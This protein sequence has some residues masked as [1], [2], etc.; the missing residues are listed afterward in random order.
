MP[1]QLC[2]HAATPLEEALGDLRISGNVLLHESYV[3]P[4]AIEVP[5]QKVLQA[6]M[7]VTADTRVVPFHLVKGGEFELS[8][9][10][11]RSL[12]AAV[13]DVVLCPGGRRH[14]MRRGRP[15]RAASM[16]CILEGKSKLRS[17]TGPKSTELICGV[18][19]MQSAP[20]SPLLASLPDYL[21]CATAGPEADPMLARAADLLAA[22]VR[23][24][25]RQ[26]GE[27]TRS[28]LLEI[29]CAEAIR[30]FQSEPGAASSGWLRAL[31]DPKVSIALSRI[32][33]EPGIAWSVEKLARLSSLSPSRFAAR[34]RDTVGTTA[35]DYVA[36]WRIQVACRLLRQ[37][38][39]SV[40][41][42]AARC[43][44]ASSATF[45][46]AFKSLVGVAPTRWHPR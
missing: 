38:Q 18:F 2:V 7:G 43:G 39:L 34:F 35:M 15:A 6:M 30:S 1:G 9:P 40:D 27:F 33:A 16:Q 4:W 32:H 37:G 45:G 21:R 31:R 10:G 41:A 11:V 20:L 14:Q 24:P 12:R 3:A 8:G 13:D 22:E 28:R 26:L 36:Q 46:R 29:F 23:T 42:I 5:D 44:Y 19:V 17:G 25:D